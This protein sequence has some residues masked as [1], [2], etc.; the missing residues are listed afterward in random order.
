MVA[1]VLAV[2]GVLAAVAGGT[3][4]AIYKCCWKSSTS[5]SK[6]D[7]GN[8]KDAL[9]KSVVAFLSDENPYAKDP[10]Q[11]TQAYRRTGAAAQGQAAELGS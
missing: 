10:H 2:A 1:P 6:K 7:R 11:Q 8:E 5:L 4:I 9:A 3:A